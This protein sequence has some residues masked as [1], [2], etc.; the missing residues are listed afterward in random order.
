MTGT[1]VICL[2]L[3]VTKARERGYLEGKP[4]EPCISSSES[5]G[6][7]KSIAIPDPESFLVGRHLSKVIGDPFDQFVQKFG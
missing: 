5:T 1:P 4:V 7:N 2:Q 6:C 3:F